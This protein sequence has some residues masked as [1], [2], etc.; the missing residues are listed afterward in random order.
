MLLMK[1]SH[2]VRMQK[3]KDPPGKGLIKMIK[4]SILNNEM[5][6]RKVIFVTF[7][8]FSIWPENNVHKQGSMLNDWNH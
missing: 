5:K 8:N 4:V 1:I 3:S 7:N 2:I 6:M